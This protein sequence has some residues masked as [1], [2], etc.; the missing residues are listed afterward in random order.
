MRGLLPRALISAALVTLLTTAARA[1]TVDVSRASLPKQL[2][3]DLAALDKLCVEA[4]GTPGDAPALI[5]AADLTG[6]G[7]ADYVVDLNEYVCAGAAS[8]LAAGQ[9][10]AAMTI[11]LGGPDNTARDVFATTS[12]GAAVTL[13]GTRPRVWLDLAGAECGQKDA[14]SLPFSDW[15]FCARP[16]NW[17]KTTQSFTLAP[18]AEARPV[19]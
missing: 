9:S 11:Y 16:L 19:D 4:G 12:Y 7:I 8:A 17:Q 13:S 5:T 18:L 6:D 10:G 14:A 15:T 2:R 1:E 3:A